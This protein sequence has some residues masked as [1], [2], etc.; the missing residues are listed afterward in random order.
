MVG[1]SPNSFSIALPA[2]SVKK[3]SDMYSVGQFRDAD[4]AVVRWT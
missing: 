4:P 2:F 3:L 1:F